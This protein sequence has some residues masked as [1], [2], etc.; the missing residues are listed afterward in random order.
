MSL[1][2]VE[3][4]I[5]Y[6]VNE[7]NKRI[8]L[9]SNGSDT[10]VT[11]FNLISENPF[12][13]PEMIL[14]ALYPGDGIQI[15]AVNEGQDLQIVNTGS[16]G[17]SDNSN[18]HHQDGTSPTV[19]FGYLH[20][21]GDPAAPLVFEDLHEIDIKGVVDRMTLVDEVPWRFQQSGFGCTLNVGAF[22]LGNQTM[23]D[24]LDPTWA[25]GYRPPVGPPLS[26]DPS[27]NVLRFEVTGLPAFCKPV[28]DQLMVQLGSVDVTLQHTHSI[29]T[30]TS[31]SSS[32]NNHTHVVGS[33]TGEANVTY[34]LG[35]SI[36]AFD[37]VTG[38]LHLYFRHL[39]SNTNTINLLYNFLRTSTF[40]LMWRAE[41]AGDGSLDPDTSGAI[42]AANGLTPT[43]S[44]VD[45]IISLEQASF[46]LTGRIEGV[47]GNTTNLVQNVAIL[48]DALGEVNQ[49]LAQEGET[50]FAIDDLL[51]KTM[52]AKANLEGATF[53]GPVNFQAG[54]NGVTAGMVGAYTTTEV[55]TALGTKANALDVTALNL[56]STGAGFGLPGTAAGLV[57]ST[58]ARPNFKVKGLTASNGIYL[59]ITL[60]EVNIS[61]DTSITDTLALKADTATVDT[62][63]ALKADTVDVK[64]LRTTPFVSLTYGVKSYVFAALGARALDGSG[65]SLTVP[66]ISS[67]AS[68]ISVIQVVAPEGY[69]RPTWT[70]VRYCTVLAQINFQFF[71]GTNDNPITIWFHDLG[72]TLPGASPQLSTAVGSALSY[73][74]TK[75]SAITN[76]SGQFNAV[77][78]ITGGNYYAM[79]MRSLNAGTYSVTATVSISV[80]YGN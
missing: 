36:A 25:L 29:S 9:M 75:N 67:A 20:M 18:Y 46:D 53:T 56:T 19:Q 54:V 77:L 48:N 74:L 42:L 28:S 47:E 45:R 66:A 1:A 64:A 31:N 23:G 24:P 62:A 79:A 65:A 52:V 13:G 44:A 27:E 71:S 32:G 63:L 37:E 14:R 40:T 26:G 33:T 7:N 80:L 6:A 15:L 68:T 72:T 55:D 43:S 58:S 78:P 35:V 49:A 5:T 30:I 2:V 50:R 38:T 70:G 76:Y 51:F 8:K 69:F 16:S 10:K 60:D 39:T 34:S 59:G 22:V 3:E 61:L 12:P 17:P 57:H 4:A 11:G 21:D 41:G 73:A